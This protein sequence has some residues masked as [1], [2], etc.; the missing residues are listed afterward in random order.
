MVELAD[1]RVTASEPDPG[2]ESPGDVY[3][4][5]RDAL[6]ELEAPV[7]RLG[8]DLTGLEEIFTAAAGGR[9]E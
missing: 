5:M 2:R 4:M 1:G 3:E 6:A 8:A 7:R 9:D